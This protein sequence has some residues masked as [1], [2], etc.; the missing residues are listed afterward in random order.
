MD[1]GRWTV[2]SGEWGDGTA[3]RRQIR[4]GA[5]AYQA[6]PCLQHQG[7]P[8]PIR[9]RPVEKYDKD[10]MRKQEE[11]GGRNRRLNE[12]RVRLD[13]LDLQ[14]REGELNRSK[15]RSQRRM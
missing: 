11:T 4:S 3:A 12:E 14:D 6:L 13:L 8:Y 2:E 1:G 9:N 5:R 10:P 7:F 15:Q